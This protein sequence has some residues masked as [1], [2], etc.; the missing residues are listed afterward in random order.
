MRGAVMTAALILYL[1]FTHAPAPVPRPPRRPPLEGVVWALE[2]HG[3]E[4]VCE[5]RPGGVWWCWWAGAEWS[6]T[7]RMDGDTLHVEERRGARHEWEMHGAS[8]RWS[9]T[10]RPGMLDGKTDSGGAFRL[11]RPK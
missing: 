3:S 8:L 9:A 6:G 2:W 1:A 5:L 4:G 7:W 11:R 10:M